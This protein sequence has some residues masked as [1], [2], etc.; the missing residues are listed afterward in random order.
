MELIDKHTNSCYSRMRELVCF[1]H[2]NSKNIFST[3]TVDSSNAKEQLKIATYTANCFLV[4]CGL[5]TLY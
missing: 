2:S 3:A 5:C 4:V 1:S